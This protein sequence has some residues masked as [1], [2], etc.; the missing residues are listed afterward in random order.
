MS[1]PHEFIF[2]NS[3]KGLCECGEPKD[4][5]IHSRRPCPHMVIRRAKERFCENVYVCGSCAMLFDVK[6]HRELPEPG[7]KEPMFDRRPPW[8][9]RNRQA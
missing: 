2:C 7:P 1:E 3:S 4:A 9:L 6:D 5:K 8:G